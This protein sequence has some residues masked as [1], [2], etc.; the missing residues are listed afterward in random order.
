MSGTDVV[1][2]ATADGGTGIAYAAVLEYCDEILLYHTGGGHDR[3]AGRPSEIRYCG[4]E[5]RYCGTEARCCGTE[6]GCCGTT[7]DIALLQE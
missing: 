2:G 6:V 5:I 7:Q 1:Y 4:T 3:V